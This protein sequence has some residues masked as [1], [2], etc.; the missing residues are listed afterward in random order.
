MRVLVVGAGAVGQVIGYH[1][2]AA[3][4]EVTFFVR[5]RHVDE[6]RQGFTLFPLHVHWPRG[7]V[8]AVALSDFSVVSRPED[9]L[10]EDFDQVYLAIPSTGLGGAWL[11]ELLRATGEATV[12]VFPTGPEDVATVRAAGL[13]ES[14]TVEGMLSLVSY[15]APMP[16]ETRF[17]RE[18]MAFWFPPLAPSLLS[19]P[20]DR[21]HAIAT[22]LQRGGMPAKR[23]RD[24][25]RVRAY[26]IAVSSV[27]LLALESVD[28]SFR[29]L[30]TGPACELASRGV[31]EAT[32]VLSAEGLRPRFPLRA[33]GHPGA[34]R[35]L[36]VVATRIVPFP[37]ETYVR[38][39]FTK[40][41]DQTRGTIRAIAARGRDAGL[42]VETLEQLADDSAT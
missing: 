1:L 16:G 2:R 40:V 19:G 6:V 30:F 42:S 18:G 17:A 4:A 41:G 7:T 8:D 13:P 12:V 37:L 22:T 10:A 14:R 39:H 15:T 20:A 11:G 35:A 9:V 5:P 25:A 3:G 21:A 26:P 24:L 36:V 27:W 31:V 33:M 23:L 38:Q 29:E 28:W 34:L 32:A